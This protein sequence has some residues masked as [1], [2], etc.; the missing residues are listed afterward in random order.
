MVADM[1]ISS[2]LCIRH[3]QTEWN[4][5]SR[6]QGRADVDLTDEGR[7]QARRAALS[8]HAMPFRFDRLICSSLR[9]AHETAQLIGEILE[10]PIAHVDE[11][12]VERDIGEWSGLH[13]SQI[14]ERWPGML[15]RWRNEGIERTPGGELE[16]DM[17]ARVSDALESALT[18][19][20]EPARTLIVT[21]GGVIHTLDNV[22]GA[23]PRPYANL[24]G[25]WYAHTPSGVQALESVTLDEVA[26]QRRGTAL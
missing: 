8:L 1:G 7:A 19:T 4:A 17:A 23:T 24:E 9:R 14:E 21:H 6:W 15:D 26:A 16:R 25:R 3:G 18:H 22:Y 2:A 11:R 5:T 20:Q 10:L 13:T 12:L